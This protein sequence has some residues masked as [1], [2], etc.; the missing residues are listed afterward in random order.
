M[1]S[2]KRLENAKCHEKKQ[3]G[4]EGM[5]HYSNALSLSLEGT[6]WVRGTH[7]GQF[8]MAM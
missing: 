6:W 5:I 3:N 1:S 8:V 4:V 7:Q 2:K